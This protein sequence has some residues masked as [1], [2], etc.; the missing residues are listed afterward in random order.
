M[1]CWKTFYIFNICLRNPAGAGFSGFGLCLPE[2]HF[3]HRE[4]GRVPP[5]RQ[6]GLRSG[7]FLFSIFYLLYNGGVSPQR[8]Q[9]LPPGSNN[10]YRL[11]TLFLLISHYLEQK[12]ALEMSREDWKEMRGVYLVQAFFILLSFLIFEVIMWSSFAFSSTETME[13]YIFTAT[14]YILLITSLRAVVLVASSFWAITILKHLPSSK[15]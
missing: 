15:E 5:F 2:R 13:R 6:V 4:H 10:H 12:W 9:D 7:F 11:F 3:P 1:I 8:G 14:S